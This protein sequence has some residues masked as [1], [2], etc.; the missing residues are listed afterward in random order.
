MRAIMRHGVLFGGILAVF[1]YGVA[2]ADP[3]LRPRLEQDQAQGEGE[4]RP[5]PPSGAVVGG[6]YS[7]RFTRLKVGQKVA[8]IACRMDR[9][10]CLCPAN[11]IRS[12]FFETDTGG[13]PAKFT[14]MCIPGS[15]PRGKALRKRIDISNGHVSFNCEEL[16]R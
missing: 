10:S 5:T 15:C 9:G 3:P 1:F 12:H 6:G 4:H 2:V 13:G 14:A 8:A 7:K 11:S 16:P